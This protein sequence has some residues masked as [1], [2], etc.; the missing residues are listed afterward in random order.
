[1]V[2]GEVMVDESVT[3]DGRVVPLCNGSLDARVVDFIGQQ[4]GS[5]NSKFGD[6]AFPGVIGHGCKVFTKAETRKR[7]VAH[8]NIRT[9]GI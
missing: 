3:C 9:E 1:M 7:R 5:L 2:W 4:T 6:L 8:K